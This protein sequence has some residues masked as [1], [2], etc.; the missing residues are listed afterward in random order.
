VWALK[1]VELTDAWPLRGLSVIPV[2]ASTFFRDRGL[3]A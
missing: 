1:S 2:L 3:V